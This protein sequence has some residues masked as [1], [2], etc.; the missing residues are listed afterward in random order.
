MLHA[1]SIWGGFTPKT[2]FWGVWLCGF[3]SHGDLDGKWAN[4]YMF[5]LQQ[6]LG[7]LIQFSGL[8]I[9]IRSTPHPVTVTTR[10]ITFLVGNPYK[11]SFATVTGWGVDLSYIHHVFLLVFFF[12][13]IT[14]KMASEGFSCKKKRGSFCGCCL[15]HGTVT[16]KIAVTLGRTM[17]RCNFASAQQLETKKSSADGEKTET[18]RVVCQLYGV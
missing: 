13:F 9:Y 2:H 15:W 4:V 18:P 7:L 8:A 16:R 10:I 17:Q 3:C 12:P 1:Q 11:P 14:L 6:S 5:V